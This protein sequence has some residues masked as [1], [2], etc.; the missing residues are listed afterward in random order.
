M[1]VIP[2]ADGE[3]IAECEEDEVFLKINHEITHLRVAEGGIDVGSMKYG[4]VLSICEVSPP[5]GFVH[6]QTCRSYEVKSET[7]Q[8]DIL[9][10]NERIIVHE[11]PPMGLD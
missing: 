1:E 8:M 10:D 6:D 7:D 5:T 9:F 3:V 11:V 4:D 2:D